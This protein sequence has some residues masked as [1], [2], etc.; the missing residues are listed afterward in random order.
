MLNKRLKVSEFCVSYSC[1]T[2]FSVCC[3]LLETNSDLHDA[4]CLFL[5][6]K[7]TFHNHQENPSHQISSPGGWWCCLQVAKSHPL[8][9]NSIQCQFDRYKVDGLANLYKWIHIFNSH[10]FSRLRHFIIPIYQEFWWAHLSTTALIDTSFYFYA[11]KGPVREDI[12]GKER[13]L[14]GIARVT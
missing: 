8:S 7:N 13:F 11:R 12:N 10:I 6:R 5:S 14:S 1:I 3:K 4:S 2:T 9:W